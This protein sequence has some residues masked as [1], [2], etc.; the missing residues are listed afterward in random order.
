LCSKLL[1][2]KAADESTR[3]EEKARAD[4]SKARDA[5]EKAKVR[6]YEVIFAL[7]FVLLAP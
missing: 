6:N 5:E 2:K 7:H 4:E 3:A 1:E